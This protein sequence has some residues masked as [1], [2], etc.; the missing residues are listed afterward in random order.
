[1]S[2]PQ[3]DADLGR[4][5]HLWF[6]P[7]RCFRARLERPPR[8]LAALAPLVAYTA[9]TSVA[10]LV[11]MGKSRRVGGCRPRGAWKQLRCL[12]PG[13]V[14]PSGSYR[15]LRRRAPYSR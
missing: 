3:A 7:V 4:I 13:S 8:Y 11:V 9:F 10:V 15:A 12:P 14:M 2:A 5:R 6:S 1:M